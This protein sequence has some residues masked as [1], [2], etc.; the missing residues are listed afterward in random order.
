M[1]VRVPFKDVELIQLYY[2]DVNLDNL[3]IFEENSTFF[4]HEDEKKDFIK[5]VAKLKLS[6]IFSDTNLIYIIHQNVVIYLTF[7]ESYSF[8]YEFE[9]F[10]INFIEGLKSH[11]NKTLYHR[12]LTAHLHWYSNLNKEIC[13]VI[14]NSIVKEKFFSTSIKSI[15]NKFHLKYEYKDFVFYFNLVATQ[16]N[17]IYYQ[18]F[19]MSNSLDKNIIQLKEFKNLRDFISGF[20]KIKGIHIKGKEKFEKYFNLFELTQY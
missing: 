17:N 1:K 19:T 12:S 8:I 16:T 4:E 10:L 6:K 14:S 13:R 9:M 20:M 7:E 18:N 5:L 2:P 11:S 15:N 3:H